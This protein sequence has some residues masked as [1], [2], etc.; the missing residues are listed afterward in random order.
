MKSKIN[1]QQE[2][3]R[4]QGTYQRSLFKT[5]RLA[6]QPV[7]TPL[8]GLFLLGF[9]GRLS[10]L[11]NTNL[12]GYWVDSF[13]KMDHCRP[14]PAWL[15]NWNPSDYIENILYLCLFGFFL[16][17]LFRIGFSRYSA[18]AISRLY[19]EVTYRTSRFPLSFFD[20][21]PAGRIITRFSSDYGNV[22]RLFGGP[23]AE[24]IAIIFDLIVMVVLITVA[25]PYYLFLVIAIIA[26]N[27]FVYRSHREGMRKERRELSLNRAPSIAHFAETAQGA[28]TIRTY[29]R[30]SVF[31]QKFQHLNDLFLDQRM[32]T[33]K[34]LTFFSLQINSLTA[35]LLLITGWTSFE[36]L[37]H[38]LVSVG[39]IGVAFTFITLSGNSV[40]TFFE[41]L[42][43]LDEALVGAERLDQYLH[44]PIEIGERLPASADFPTPHWSA[45][46]PPPCRN[47]ESTSSK[48]SA[49]IEFKNVSF[50]YRDDLPWVLKNINLSVRAGERL[51]IVGK[52]GSG[53][54]SLIQ[55]L[56]Y[57][58]PLTEGSISI[59][60]QSPYLDASSPPKPNQLNLTDYRQ[61]I[62]LIP[63]DPVLFRGSLRENLQMQGSPSDQTLL[64]PIESVG[65]MP[66]Y[67]ALPDGLDYRI[68]ERGKN[69]SQGERQLIC[70]ARS[71]VQN[72]PIIVM[73]E[74]TS[75]VDPQSEQIML[76]ATEKFFAQ[77]TQLIIA[78]RLSTLEHCDRILWLHNG[79]IKMLGTPNEV[80]PQFIDH[81]KSEVIV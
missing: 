2:E 31:M 14:L 62:T 11:L 69:L 80:L 34:K 1:F 59:D 17:L 49:T 58:Y 63:Q 53:K 45:K 42:A 8:Y 5:L 64:S 65:L 23:L 61:L 43:Q 57:L 6:Y 81:H 35:L 48:A 37:Q 74:A 60:G 12:F 15:Q 52:T 28:S 30:Q 26:C 50:R 27:F 33:F 39:D 20:T 32:K 3:T 56:F 16:T 77:R 73:D 24:F 19:D 36:L 18:V 55:I 67:S 9:L 75:A 38:Q 10:L 71:L 4:F 21:T 41:W 44:L 13:C 66:W 40:Q 76:T 7:L 46:S 70:M 78:H 22:F 51:G 72:A 29:L 25:S 79:E 54:S 47:D 68:E